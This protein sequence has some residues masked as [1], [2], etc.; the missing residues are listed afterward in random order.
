MK[1]ISFHKSAKMYIIYCFRNCQFVLFFLGKTS[2][3]NSV[4]LGMGYVGP[5]L[6][7]L[8]HYGRLNR[9]VVGMNGQTLLR[10][11]IN[12]LKIANIIHELEPLA[13]HSVKS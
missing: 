3:F 5:Y 6:G 12:E 13:G 9:D 7:P 4:D 1:F 11:Q 8:A 2:I 10:V